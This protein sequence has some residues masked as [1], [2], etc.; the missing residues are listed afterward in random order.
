MKTETETVVETTSHIGIVI[1]Q[2][3]DETK[4]LARAQHKLLAAACF[5]FH[6]LSIQEIKVW[7]NYFKELDKL[8]KLLD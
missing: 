3:I 6:I 4:T 8:V 2:S 1:K 7:V 5:D